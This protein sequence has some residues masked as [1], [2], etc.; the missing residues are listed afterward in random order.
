MTLEEF[1]KNVERLK[2]ASESYYNTDYTTM[3]DNEYDV[4]V[5]KCREYDNENNIIYLF[6]NMQV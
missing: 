2:I 5:N 4:L 1:N 3:T 6:L